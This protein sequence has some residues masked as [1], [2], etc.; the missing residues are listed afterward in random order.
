MNVLITT[1]GRRGTLTKIFKEEL[2]KIGG[3]VIVTDNS[4]LAP[5]LYQADN[6]YLTP[7]V[8]DE[9]YIERIIEICQKEEIKVIIPLLEKSFPIFDRARDIFKE[10][11]IILLLSKAE[12]FE[13]CKDK[14]KLYEYFKGNSILTPESYL[15]QDL[16]SDFSFPLFIKPRTG[17]GSQD[18]FKVK[19]QKEL[20]FFSKYIDNPIIQEYIEGTEYTID[21]LSDLEGNLL[22]AVP[23]KRIEV[24]SGEVSK[25]VTVKDDRLIN[26]AKNIIEDLGIIGP[27]NLQAIITPE[28]EIKFIELNPRFGGGVPLS[29]QAGIN[30]PL[31]ISKMVKGEE[32]RPFLGNFEDG[33]AMLRYDTP[34]FRRIDE[35][36]EKND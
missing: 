34:L 14:Y 20:N 29:Y 17:Q 22:S 27:A 2:N 32:V 33:L 7:R 6:Y 1:I 24:R 11:G 23:R 25:S 26:W 12:T 35:L 36:G 9:N 19:D 16:G 28:D 15:C 21:T 18:I 4:P 30:Y 5:A 8:D 3:K 10:K 13:K 31:L